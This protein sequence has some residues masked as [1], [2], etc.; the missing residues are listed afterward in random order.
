MQALPLP[1]LKS[2]AVGAEGLILFACRF[3]ERRL[4]RE[5]TVLMIFK[6][7]IL[8]LWW[9]VNWILLSCQLGL[10][11]AEP[12]SMPHLFRSQAR[13]RTYYRLSRAV[14]RRYKIQYP[15]RLK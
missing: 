4:Y 1:F 12:G 2:L 7:A 10:K 6:P 14:L 8:C 9:R 5:N 15:Y 13:V 3:C 11:L